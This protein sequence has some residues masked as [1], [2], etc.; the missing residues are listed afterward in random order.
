[1]DNN[2]VLKSL[3]CDICGKEKRQVIALLNDKGNEIK[4]CLNCNNKLKAKEKNE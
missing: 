4:V 1:M 3:I 2:T